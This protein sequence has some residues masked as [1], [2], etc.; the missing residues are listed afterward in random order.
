MSWDKDPRHHGSAAYFESKDFEEFRDDV[1]GSERGHLL[2][3][4]AVVEFR[5]N[6]RQDLCRSLTRHIQDVL[7]PHFQWVAS[8][9][10]WRAL[11]VSERNAAVREGRE[12]V[13]AAVSL[14]RSIKKDRGIDIPFAW[15]NSKE[16]S[17]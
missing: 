10:D 2:D 7:I 3:L 12:A 13:I 4:S 1:V 15:V 9:D 6:L 14:R 17:C 8:S 5:E 16:E 11:S